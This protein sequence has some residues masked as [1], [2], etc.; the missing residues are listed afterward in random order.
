MADHL[1]HMSPAVRALNAHK[2][3]PKVAETLTKRKRGRPEGELVDEIVS[4]L[5]ELGY[6]VVH[7]RPARTAEGWRTPVQGDGAG[8]QDITA[9]GH[10]RAVVIEAKDTNGKVTDAQ[11]EWLR[12]WQRVPGVIALV[13]TPESWPHYRELL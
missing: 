1:K 10:G 2:L 4:D 13:V 8:Y 6:L 3:E 11:Y 5:Q 12:E 9:V 7:F